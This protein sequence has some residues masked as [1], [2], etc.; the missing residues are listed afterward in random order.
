MG[1]SSHAYLQE[2]IIEV[3]QKGR[4]MGGEPLPI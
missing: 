4:T 2:G 3:S 1:L